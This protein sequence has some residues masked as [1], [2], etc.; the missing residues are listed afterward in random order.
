MLPAF[1]FDG[2]EKTR[3]SNSGSVLE[4]EYRN[5]ICRFRTEDGVIRDA[6][7]TGCNRNGHY[8]IFRAEGEK[9]LTVS[10]DIRPRGPVSRS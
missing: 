3:I 10:I 8:R 4:V 5:W 6:G 9:S 7:K 1:E 2:R